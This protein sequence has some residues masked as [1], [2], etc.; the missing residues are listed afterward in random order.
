MKTLKFV[1]VLVT[2]C[3][4]T[5]LILLFLIAKRINYPPKLLI[6]TISQAYKQKDN[7]PSD[8]NFLI[9]GVDKR[10]DWLETSQDTDTI[11]FANLDTDNLNLK[12]ISLPRDIWFKSTSSRINKIYQLSFS[13]EDPA[14]FV[15]QSF[16][17]IVGLPI[18]HLIVI[19]TKVMAPIVKAV[20][21][22]E[23][24]LKN[25]YTDDR[26]PDPNHITDPD[27]YPNPYIT[28]S[29]DQGVNTINGQNVLY[30]VRS[31]KGAETIVDGGTD[32][33]RLDRQQL[34][35]E[36]IFQKLKQ[37]KSTQ[38]SSLVSLYQIWSQQ[39]Q[40]DIDDQTILSIVFKNKFN[41][42]KLNLSSTGLPI[43]DILAGTVGVIYHPTY[44]SNNAW[45][46]LPTEADFS[47][48][49]QFIDQ[50]IN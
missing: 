41:I 1:A 49:H 31:R 27:N 44:F 18:D 36:S 48:I 20:G 23:I 12:L 47:S 29:F 13:Q 8:I 50:Q 6:N 39:I 5:L 38:F 46:Y 15:K 35:L 21:P 10:S 43:Q 30:F 26:Y 45:V 34:L 3:S 19:D 14:G 16:Q 2:A 32:I 9:L 28:I 25:A 11:I 42:N 40:Q 22:L 4:L 17:T 24:N 7:L 33:G 37:T